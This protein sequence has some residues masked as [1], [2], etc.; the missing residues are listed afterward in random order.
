[1]LRRSPGSVRPAL[2]RWGLAACFSLGIGQHAPG[3]DTDHYARCA[4]CHLDDG[5]GVPGLFPPLKGHV[6]RFFATRDGRSYLA[7][8]VVGG[9]TG[10][11][12]IQGVRY[13][14]AMPAVVADL[15]DADVADLLTALVA[16]FGAAGPSSGF[17]PQDVAAAR[18]A[19]RLGST[20]RTSLRERALAMDT[21][22]ARLDW[23]LHCSGCHGADG[24][25]ATSGMAALHGRVAQG[26]A[27]RAG[28]A[29]LVQVPGVTNTSLSDARLAGTL[30]W[31]LATFDG[32]HLPRDFKAFTAREVGALR[33]RAANAPSTLSND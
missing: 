16:R 13:M 10:S 2:Q 14:G 20:E 24:H 29:R 11:V 18:F 30:N 17:T 19:G 28:R 9:T 23:L 33:W 21:S 25:V 15:S 7:R 4:A 5:A 1:M 3:A 27:T 6:Q 8:L 31:M 32:E 12:D 22:Q 26:V